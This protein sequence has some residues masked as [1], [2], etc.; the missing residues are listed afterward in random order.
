[1]MMQF[2]P[3]EKLQTALPASELFAAW[4]AGRL[5][6]PF[7]EPGH[8][9]SRAELER[10]LAS[11][12]GSSG[13]APLFGS[14]WVPGW[15]EDLEKDLPEEGDRTTFRENLVRL[16][17][18]TADVVVTGQQPG[19]LGGPLYT[20]YKIATAVE[21][22]HWRTSKGLPTVPVFWSGDDD[23]DLAEALSPVAW[24]SDQDRPFRAPALPGDGQRNPVI[25]RLSR[26]PW[27]EQAASWLARSAG[28]GKLAAELAVLWSLARA[29]DWPLSRVNRRLVLRL[30]AGS[31]LMV[32]SG[33][34]PGLHT[35][36]KPL[37]E[38]VR[39]KGEDLQEA[40]RSRGRELVDMGW[41]AQI[42]DRSLAR[43]LFRIVDG[44]R[45]PQTSAEL[46]ADTGEIRPGV[47]LRSPVQDWLLR[48][49]AVVVGP[50]ELAYLRQLDSVYGIL[51]VA[52]PP[53]VPRLFAW[54][55]P[56]EFPVRRFEDFRKA[57][58]VDP[59]AGARLA[60]RA[61]HEAG[62][63]LTAILTEEVGLPPDRAADLAAGRTRRW[64]KGVEA[65]LNDEMRRQAER[66]APSRPGWVFP[67]GQRQ[68]RKL[69]LG[70]AASLWGEDFVATVRSAARAHLEMGATGDWREF[71]LEVPALGQ[72]KVK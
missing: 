22:A 12:E 46:P 56:P 14:S 8:G 11:G 9:D 61:A 2:K 62:R 35:V 67:A 26:Q 17:D 20:L 60:D 41:H 44:R 15:A 24:D 42:N 70:C 31:G 29:E 40:G 63:I 34:D 10:A 48:P 4:V 5:N 1:M 64:R 30:F 25:G 19:F 58:Q 21:L 50:G 32:V 28:S 27:Q 13:P 69:A 23:D 65:M 38:I 66:A 33:D 52:R 71:T 43:P 18:G 36:A 16:R 37:Y 72:G 47:M 53:L 7:L 45:V 3:Q 51:G 54:A 55:V 57:G 49:A 39:E 6:A 68:E 59:A